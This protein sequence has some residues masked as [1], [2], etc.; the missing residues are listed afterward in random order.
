M[1][2]VTSLLDGIVAAVVNKAENECSDSVLAGKKMQ[3]ALRKSGLFYSCKDKAYRRLR[4][5]IRRRKE[6]I[7]AK[8][9]P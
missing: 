9:S 6:R 5:T 2:D 8:T 4:Q 3:I 1:V 7:V